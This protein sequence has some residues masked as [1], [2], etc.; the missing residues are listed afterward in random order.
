MR[1]PILAPVDQD[2][3]APNFPEINVCLVMD[4]DRWIL[5]VQ[6]QVMNDRQLRIF[7]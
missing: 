7:S 6:L 2:S 4:E 3:Q 5:H 1:V